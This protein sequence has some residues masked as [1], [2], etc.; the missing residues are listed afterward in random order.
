MAI[1]SL[2]LWLIL[3][4]T[5]T[6][7]VQ[8][9][10][11]VP[12]MPHSMLGGWL[13]AARGSGE[14]LNNDLLSI[15]PGLLEPANERR[16]IDAMR[17]EPARVL[18]PLI[19]SL[20]ELGVS[21]EP[22]VDELVKL[23]RHPESEV[24]SQAIVAVSKL[25][26]R[27]EKRLVGDV[28]EIIDSQRKLDE[29]SVDSTRSRVSAHAELAREIELLGTTLRVRDGLN[30]ERF[31]S[32]AGR[33]IQRVDP[34][35]LLALAGVSAAPAIRAHGFGDRF[36]YRRT[37]DIT[38][39]VRDANN[40]N[41]YRSIVQLLRFV[42]ADVPTIDLISLA[43]DGSPLSSGARSGALLVALDRSDL[44]LSSA[45]PKLIGLVASRERLLSTLALRISIEGLGA[46]HPDFQRVLV[47]ARG[48]AASSEANLVESNLR[49]V[50]TDPL[51]ALA[52]LHKRLRRADELKT[53]GQE[54]EQVAVSTYLQRLY[55]A[56]GSIPRSVRHVDGDTFTFL[57][58][59]LD[60][61]HRKAVVGSMSRALLV[62]DSE[63]VPEVVSN[64][65]E[66]E[67]LS[68]SEAVE[69]IRKVSMS[70][71]AGNALV[72]ST[73]LM[74]MAS[75]S[76]R[77]RESFNLL[78]PMLE[79][80]S[81]ELA[82]QSTPPLERKS[83]RDLID[84]KAFSHSLEQFLARAVPALDAP[85]LKRLEG[86]LRQLGQ[87]NEEDLIDETQ[88]ALIRRGDEVAIEVLR[89][90]LQTMQ[91]RQRYGEPD[92]CRALWSAR[93]L[94]VAQT[95][96]ALYRD[97]T[98]A[99]C[100]GPTE[101]ALESEA[102]ESRF[103]AL[104]QV[105]ERHREI[106]FIDEILVLD[107]PVKSAF[108]FGAIVDGNF[109]RLRSEYVLPDSKLGELLR[110][111]A[112]AYPDSA[113]AAL[114]DC[115]WD[116]VRN[117]EHKR[118]FRLARI[119]RNAGAIAELE[120]LYRVYRNDWL[121]HTARASGAA[122]EQMRQRLLDEGRRA[123]S[124]QRAVE[125]LLSDS[126]M[127]ANALAEDV[128]S[129]AHDPY[130]AL[131]YL[132]EYEALTPELAAMIVL[133]EKARTGGRWYGPES[134]LLRSGID[135]PSRIGRRVDEGIVRL[136]TSLREGLANSL[137]DLQVLGG[138]NGR[139]ASPDLSGEFAKLPPL[140]PWPP[141]Y[142]HAARLDDLVEPQTLIRRGDTIGDVVQRLRSGLA[143]VDSRFESGVFGVPNG[144]IMLTRVERS[145]AEGRP[146][147]GPSRWLKD[148]EVIPP[149]SI[150][151][152]AAAMFRLKP[153]YSRIFGFLFVVQGGL[154]PSAGGIVSLPPPRTGLLEL[155]P[156]LGTMP[157]DLFERFAL[158]FSYER[159]PGA[160]PELDTRLSAAIHLQRSGFLRVS[161]VVGRAAPA[162]PVDIR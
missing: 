107:S 155:P 73:A 89:A 105:I 58:S 144:F 29:V 91:G 54:W 109:D 87:L 113:M 156:S 2:C 31:L 45:S 66:P 102:I 60:A 74:G 12:V 112:L 37:R 138:A 125:R 20:G 150:R 72:G 16:L 86:I 64:I 153:G 95:V 1:Y 118:C 100:P 28:I 130:N 151:E 157:A 50:R 159:K 23:I 133:A 81:R 67:A 142:S 90:L 19:R 160:L 63:G 111:A 35:G 103:N 56:G 68:D 21:R 46:M 120:A 40:H 99:R 96:M 154:P 149:G 106:E 41:V 83:D 71:L 147:P 34:E 129:G 141:A 62:A 80:A 117:D 10:T 25:D 61:R 139:A 135:E 70:R 44:Y 26:D 162:P 82:G 27:V 36:F 110:R 13:D 119:V 32:A 65:S 47:A 161:G 134:I 43:S 39:D 77:I 11:A 93:T 121:G 75:S 136:V 94:R 146:L 123:E 9:Q 8:A 78:F 24:A 49:L 152:Y 97:M 128:L 30:I 38:L 5:T 15:P 84:Q 114:R 3:L 132:S 42:L 79:K 55:A 85:D 22:V 124:G 59:R 51:S 76:E 116:Q 52:V 48:G 143:G 122:D 88:V 108:V 69:L 92:I 126:P 140:R 158:V 4:F 7:L 127:I 104:L 33:S 115:P 6:P 145:D 148:T 17:T 57:F 101:D 98:G 53:R 14:D 131:R 137:F 18:V